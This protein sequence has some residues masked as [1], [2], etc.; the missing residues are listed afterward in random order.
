MTRTEES[1]T[2][3]KRVGTPGAFS[4]TP[5]A[6]SVPFDFAAHF[7][8]SVPISDPLKMPLVHI[9]A[10]SI[11]TTEGTT[12]PHVYATMTKA[13]TYKHAFSPDDIR[14][15]SEIRPESL[16]A[17][18][19][20]HPCPVAHVRV[21]LL[22]RTGDIETTAPTTP[23]LLSTVKLSCASPIEGAR[24]V[25]SIYNEHDLLHKSEGPL[26]SVASSQL[27]SDY[28]CDF[29]PQFWSRVV[30]GQL[31]NEGFRS[32]FTEVDREQRRK[33]IESYLPHCS[34]VQQFIGRPSLEQEETVLV[35]L[36]EMNATRDQG[37]VEISYFCRDTTPLQHGSPLTESEASAIINPTE[38]I[39]QG[40]GSSTAP[41]DNDPLSSHPRHKPSLSLE[42][43]ANSMSQFGFGV[44][45]RRI[46]EGGVPV[47][48]A[49]QL[50]HKPLA[51]PPMPRVMEPTMKRRMENLWAPT[52]TERTFGP[53]DSAIKNSMPLLPSPGTPY[54][55]LPNILSSATRAM[56]GMT[57]DAMDA[58]TPKFEA[59]SELPSE[60]STKTRLASPPRIAASHG[61]DHAKDTSA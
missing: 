57:Q 59:S 29:A 18:I 60:D 26:E 22:L 2:K 6:F 34:I 48:P 17:M 61:S 23:Q 5:G 36:Y 56:N 24:C 37:G 43:P 41:M 53:F 27:S 30:K 7:N 58:G 15:C 32:L 40:R 25:T 47:T 11:R 38:N 4:M 19:E 12:K 20:Q 46:A 51:P 45:A 31:G 9:S 3:P 28:K 55:P 16:Q 10:L 14:Q 49:A 52:P 13:P 42:I 8:A 50:I 39:T 54:I 21:N 44:N 35:V 33:T 1:S